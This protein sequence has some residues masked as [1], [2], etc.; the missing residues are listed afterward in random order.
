MIIISASGM[1]TGGRILHHLAASGNDPNNAIV[2]SGYQAAG[3]RGA[4]LAA[5][6]RELR[7]YGQDIRIRAEVVQLEGFSAHADSDA[8]IRWMRSA[9]Q[10]PGMTYITHGEPEASDALRLRI[11]HELGWKARVPEYTETISIAHPE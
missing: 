8:I 11:K 3:T 5:G 6:S 1:L 2:L 10:A 4:A 9:P 7:V